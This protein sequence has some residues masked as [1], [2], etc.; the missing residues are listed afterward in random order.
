MRAPDGQSIGQGGAGLGEMYSSSRE[1][2]AWCIVVKC[3]VEKAKDFPSLRQSAKGG[4]K[5][6]VLFL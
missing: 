1:V 6:C 3:S 4:D 2:P 5:C